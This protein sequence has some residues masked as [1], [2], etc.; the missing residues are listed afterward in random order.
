MVGKKSNK[1]SRNEEE[2]ESL[3]NG[4]MKIDPPTPD[5]SNNS[6][7]NSVTT[8]EEYTTVDED[9][10]EKC[11]NYE[12]YRRQNRKRRHGRKSPKSKPEETTLKNTYEVLS[13]KDVGVDKEEDVPP[14]KTFPPIVVKT[15]MPLKAF[16]SCVRTSI[17]TTTNINFKSGKGTISIYT[18]SA[19]DF[20]TTQE[21]LKEKLFE[22]HTFT[23]KDDR[24][25]R[26]VIK[27]L[28]SEYTPEEV[29]EDLKKLGLD[30]LKVQNMY[31]AKKTFSNMFLVSFP[32]TVQLNSVLKTTKFKY[33]CYQKVEW[34]N[35]ITNNNGAV[36]C[37]R[38]Q[39]FGH[40]AS[41]C[42]Y[43]QR[44]VKCTTNHGSDKCPKDENT[45]VACVNCGGEHSSNFRGCP[46]Y[47][48][49]VSNLELIRTKPNKPKTT[50]RPM[51]VFTTPNISYSNM[52]KNANN[53]P[54]LTQ[55]TNTNFSQNNN[56]SSIKISEILT[57]KTH[58]SNPIRIQSQRQTETPLTFNEEVNQL[59]NC[60][61]DDLGALLEDFLPK[62]RALKTVN[63][64]RIEIISFLAQFP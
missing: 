64:K 60:S 16:I 37:F 54:R 2:D 12:A 11:K 39:R 44:C 23:P 27:G 57:P 50:A 45:K 3:G 26:L 13:Q 63:A 9:T 7:S 55:Q 31:K 35:Y 20:K 33:I 48:N 24:I 62:L 40:S 59:F 56:T 51:T 14:T 4:P 18:T 17:S 61:L 21:K 42:N 25:K 46:N 29:E 30:F 52:T 15:A 53:F 1:K 47:I 41:N 38:C 22:F 6:E 28:S 58:D 8:D 49:Y 10:D 43:N 34:C 36:Q 32:K 19:A 5:K